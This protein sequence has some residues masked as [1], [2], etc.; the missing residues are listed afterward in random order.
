MQVLAEEVSNP[1]MC[2][3]ESLQSEGMTVTGAAATKPPPPAC[4]F[5]LGDASRIFAT[6]APPSVIFVRVQVSRI[7]CGGGAFK[8]SGMLIFK[9]IAFT[10]ETK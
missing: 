4:I 6:E 8:L 1:G 10:K 5:C 2:M 7:T 9:L 3:N